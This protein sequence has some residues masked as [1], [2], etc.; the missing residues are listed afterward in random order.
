MHLAHEYAQGGEMTDKDQNKKG[1]D[2]RP[3]YE[4]PRALSL[5][6]M[7]TGTGGISVCVGGSNPL[8]CLTGGGGGW[9]GR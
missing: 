3:V 7:H 8:D 2:A 1:T 6:D 9:G 4:P 5:S